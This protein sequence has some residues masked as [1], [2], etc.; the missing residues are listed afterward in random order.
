LP[1][2]IIASVI[3]IVPSKEVQN[4]LKTYFNKDGL[5][6]IMP[7][8]SLGNKLSLDHQEPAQLRDNEHSYPPKNPS[9]PHIEQDCDRC[10]ARCSGGGGHTHNSV[11]ARRGGQHFVGVIP[12]ELCPQIIVWGVIAPVALA[13]LKIPVTCTAPTLPLAMAVL[14]MPPIVPSHPA[15]AG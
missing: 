14:A 9:Q 5:L 11:T 6:F 7:I 12:I 15:K 1:L 2:E 8:S 4:I 10:I 3:S 13:T